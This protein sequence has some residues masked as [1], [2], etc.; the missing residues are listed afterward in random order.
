MGNIFG[1][2]VLVLFD[3]YFNIGSH[4]FNI[5][6]SFVGYLLILRGMAAVEGSALWRKNDL[7]IGAFVYSLLHWVGLALVGGR[8]ASDLIFIFG[9]AAA[10]LQLLVTRRIAKGF[11]ELEREI[12]ADKYGERL[13]G[14][15]KLLVI[16]MVGANI[17]LLLGL[18]AFTVIINFVG[19]FLYLLCY[20]QA[21]K[22]YRDNQP[23]V[24]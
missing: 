7:V 3:F 4:S 20:C 12:G 18:S 23:S 21:W 6:P 9:V 11:L 22:W 1:G 10:V 5:L 24:R 15:W 2:L 8:I 19:A 14:G 17:L 13:M 16:A